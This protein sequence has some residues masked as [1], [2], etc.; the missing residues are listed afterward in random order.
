VQIQLKVT[1]TGN[2]NLR[3]VW[4]HYNRQKKSWWYR[5][6]LIAWMSTTPVYNH[7]FVYHWVPPL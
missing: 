6:W 2:N 4:R 3:W 1:A 5:W 7:S